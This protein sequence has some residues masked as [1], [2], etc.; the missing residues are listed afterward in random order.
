MLLL[1]EPPERSI[2]INNIPSSPAGFIPPPDRSPPMLMFC[3][4]WSKLGVWFPI[5]ALLERTQAK[6]FPSPP[7]KRLPFVSTSS[8]PS[9]GPPGIMIGACQVIPP[10]VERW[11]CTPPPLQ[12]I[13]SSAWYWKP[14]PGPLV[15]SMVNHSLSPPPAPLSPE[16]NVQD[17]PPFS[18]RHK[19][20]Q[21]KDWLTS[22]WR[23]R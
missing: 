21:K 4:T 10:S 7:I 5:C 19:S 3:V 2:A 22:D 16:S 18:E 11:N 1:V 23:L 17:W 20:S 13:P 8:V 14:C 9:V 15:L 6:V 12:L